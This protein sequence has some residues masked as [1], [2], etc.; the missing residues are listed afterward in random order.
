[1][2]ILTSRLSTTYT[3]QDSIYTVDL[4][5]NNV[6]LFLNMMG[7]DELEDIDKI[8]LGL[9]ILLDCCFL[10]D[11]KQRSFI[12]KDLIATF[13]NK[14]GAEPELDIAG[15]PMPHQKSEPFSLEHDAEYIYS[16]FKKD[17]DIDLQE[18]F[19]K[20]DWRKFQILLRD[21]SEDTKFK[22]VIDIRERPLPTGKGSGKEKEQ[23]NKMKK[24]YALPSHKEKE[25]D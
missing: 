14:D 19:N 7:D 5:F 4:A 18:E 13:I 12:L 16:S 20:L 24:L 11:Y 15:N 22:K 2:S 21:L 6:I 1:M 17:Y 23:L 9:E 25:G 3:Y 8:D 10:I